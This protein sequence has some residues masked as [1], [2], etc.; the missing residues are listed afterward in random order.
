MSSLRSLL[1]LSAIALLLS[2]CAAAVVGGAATATGV[3][4]AH[5]RRATSTIINDRNLQLSVRREIN[6]DRALAS[7]NRI[8]VVVYNRVILLV[9]EVAD[10]TARA[11]AG[12]LASNFIGTRRLVN[13][14]DI[15]PAQG[16]WARRGDNTLGARIKTGLLDITSIPGFDPSRVAITVAHGK[17]YLMGLVTR[18]E[19][20][21]VIENARHTRGVQ[22]VLNLFE[23]LGED[24][25]E[26]PPA[27]TG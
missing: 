3:G 5:D 25:T 20:A 22:E 8:R 15:L 21:A 18:A 12:E 1:L 11:R 13:E 23:Y 17:V 9:G 6:G 10:E 27:A 16:F 4:V 24:V 14:L 2:G 7:H 19:A 26:E